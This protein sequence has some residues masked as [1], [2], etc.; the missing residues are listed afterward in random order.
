VGQ[1]DQ[2]SAKADLQPPY[3]GKSK[4]VSENVDFYHNIFLIVAQLVAFSV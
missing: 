4:Q 3:R 2:P 1:L